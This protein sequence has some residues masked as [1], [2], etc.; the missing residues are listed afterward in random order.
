MKRAVT[1]LFLVVLAA[2]TAEAQWFSWQN[3]N[4]YPEDLI[5]T[6]YA[7]SNVRI[8]D[9]LFTSY[10]IAADDFET[11]QE[12]TRIT[13]IV[14]WSVEVGEPWIK[15]GDWYLYAG[16]GGTPGALVAHE[17]AVALAHD[18]TGFEHPQFGPIYANVMV[19]K[20]LSLSRGHYFL[21]FRT[22][23]DYNPS[24]KNNNTALSTVWT[25]G[26]QRAY[27]NFGVL[28]DGTVTEPWQL[29]E[30]FNL[31]RDN[32]WA[33][34]IRGGK[35][36]DLNCDG[37]VNN[38]DIDPFVLALVDPVGYAQR[39]PGCDRLLGDANG[40]GEVNNF[41]IDPFVKCMILDR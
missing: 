30:V 37:A 10:R 8:E 4:R 32:E 18:K 26:R 6:P 1:F 15:G 35:L 21:A 7:W 23:Q 38:F 41:D 5:N 14:F 40:D 36:C 31:V 11:T 25:N 2:A 34:L 19:P 24:G 27:W 20:N 12:L 17:S 33:F 39:F 29:L 3:V 22:F 16:G 9:P 13:K 28:A